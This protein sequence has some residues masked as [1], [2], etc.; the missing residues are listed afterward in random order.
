MFKPNPNE[1]RRVMIDLSGH[2]DAPDMAE[3]SHKDSCDIH[4]IM[5]K[6]KKAGVLTHVNQFQGTYGD[7]SGAPE[8]KEAQD[9]IANAASMFETVPAHIRTDMDNDAQTFINFM[10]N[11]ENRAQIEEYGLDASHLPPPDSIPTPATDTNP[12]LNPP[13]GDPMQE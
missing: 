13:Q 8:Y 12:L 5:K 9:I 10:Q 1:R 11:P 7:F 4:Q 3:Q 2:L 6:Y